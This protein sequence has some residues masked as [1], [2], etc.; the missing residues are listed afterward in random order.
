[1]QVLFLRRWWWQHLLHVV[2]SRIEE[3]VTCVLIHLTRNVYLLLC[4][5][6]SEISD[7]I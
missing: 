5:T 6:S 3:V 1:M 7:K 4:Q 2:N